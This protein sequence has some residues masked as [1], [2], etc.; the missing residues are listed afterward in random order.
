MEIAKF[1]LN[2]PVWLDVSTELG[3]RLKSLL[4]EVISKLPE[5]EQFHTPGIIAFLYRWEAIQLFPHSKGFADFSMLGRVANCVVAMNNETNEVQYI[6]TIIIDKL[7]SMPDAYIKG[8][9]AHELGEM[10]FMV[11]A[12]IIHKPDF[13]KMSVNDRK[14]WQ[15]KFLPQGNIGSS[16]N[17]EHERLANQEAIRLGFSEELGVARSLYQNA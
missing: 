12:Y 14:S 10:S 17:L 4:Y 5:E 1:F 15:R 11:G 13:R 2:V 7:H 8:L 16:E 9:I 3:K 6:I